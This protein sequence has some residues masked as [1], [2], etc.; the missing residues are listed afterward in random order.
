MTEKQFLCELR[1]SLGDLSDKDVKDSIEYY[2]EMIADKCEGG[3]SEEEAVAELGTPKAAAREIMMNMSLPKL[4][5]NKCR[6]KKKLA[7]WEMVLLV[8]GSPVWLSLAVAL[9]AVF[10]SVYV[11]I[12]SVA[13]SLFA[14]DVS[15]AA[16]GIACVIIGVYTLF[17][18]PLTG[19]IYLGVGLVFVGV[20]VPLFYVC[21][22]TVK[23]F[24]K[25]SIMIL[26]WIKRMF[27]SKGE[28]EG[29]DI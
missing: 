19:L 5:K 17:S 11:C 6:P 28:K 24:I 10:I 14:V 2:R 3:M 21:R 15:L 20:C 13:I 7:V 27:I 4:I 29:T 1:R 26:R 18:V 12:W 22:K 8:L 9:F 16:S 23:W 25:I